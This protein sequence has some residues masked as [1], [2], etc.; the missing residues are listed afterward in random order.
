MACSFDGHNHLARR[1]EAEKVVVGAEVRADLPR[2]NTREARGGR[3]VRGPPEK[4]GLVNVLL[5]RNSNT[6][7]ATPIDVIADDGF[8]VVVFTSSFSARYTTRA[9]VK[10][11][12]MSPFISCRQVNLLTQWYISARGMI[13]RMH[14]LLLDEIQVKLSATLERSVY[15]GKRQQVRNICLA[16]PARSSRLRRLFYSSNVSCL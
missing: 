12:V 3:K 8:L 9:C 5:K 1:L 13:R 15:S 14:V 16:E 4:F 11:K 6:P 2:R 10:G 7:A